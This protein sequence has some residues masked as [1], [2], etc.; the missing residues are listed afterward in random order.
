MTDN[1]N[2]DD[3]LLAKLEQEYEGTRIISV[4]CRDGRPPRVEAPKDVS[5]SDVIATLLKAVL[6]ICMDDFIYD[7]IDEVLEDD[8]DDEDSGSE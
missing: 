4:V 3:E 5:E 7:I 1:A 6:F 8:E 2:M